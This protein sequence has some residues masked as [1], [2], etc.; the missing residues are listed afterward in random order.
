MLS[1]I[2]TRALL[3]AA[4]AVGALGCSTTDSASGPSDESGT[5]VTIDERAGTYRGVGLGSSRRAARQRLGDGP[6]GPDEP[7]APVGRKPLVT[8]VPPGPRTPA[9]RAP[10]TVWRF[11]GAAMV[12][13]DGEAWLAVFAAE[14]ARTAAGVGVGSRLDEARKAYPG[15]YCAIANAGTEYVSFDFCTARVSAGRYV[16]FAYDPIR[17]VT[18]SRAPLACPPTRSRTKIKGCPG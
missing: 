3:V 17:S 5:P 10:S 7:L 2:P 13:D 4:L 9:G 11:P 8:G 1:S 12:A 15:S 6:A 16:W 14:D 18:V